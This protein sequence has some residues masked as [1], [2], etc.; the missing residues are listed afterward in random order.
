MSRD[1]MLRY[2]S[3]AGPVQVSVNGFLLENDIVGERSATRLEPYVLPGTNR[4]RVDASAA[5]AS[6]VSIEIAVVPDDGRSPGVPVIQLQHP[7]PSG[8]GG[9]LDATFQLPP[10]LPAWNWAQLQPAPAGA[11]ATLHGFLTHFAALLAR[12]PDDELLRLLAYK[13]TEIAA[14]LGM[15]KQE[16]DQGL[17]EGL[18]RRRAT[19]GF[20]V[21]VAAPSDLVPLW[22]PDRRLLRPLRRT[23]QDALL[24]PGAAGPNGFELVLGMHRNT[25]IIIR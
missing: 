6:R 10:D 2:I 11:E 7:G 20:R 21:D 14:A 4:I 24:L 12:G 25:W 19:P 17:L 8:A 5:P 23:R 16:M 13:H 9:I 3:T 1:L 22:S 18:A 15:A